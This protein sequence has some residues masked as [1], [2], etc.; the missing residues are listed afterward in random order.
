MYNTKTYC[1][2][3]FITNGFFVLLLASGQ[4]RYNYNMEFTPRPD[5]MEMQT[6]VHTFPGDRHVTKEQYRACINHGYVSSVPTVAGAARAHGIG[7]DTETFERWKRTA[8][9]A[10]LLDD[11]LDTSGDLESAY[12]LYTQGVHYFRGWSEAPVA[13]EE[14]DERLEPG[15]ILLGNAVS[16]LPQEQQGMLCEAAESIAFIALWKAGCWYPDD[17]ADYSRPDMFAE[18][19][20]YEAAD[21]ARLIT[22]TASKSV[23]EHPNFE[24][25][26][27][28]CTQ[29]ITLGALVNN[30]LDLKEDYEHELV[31]VAPTPI[32]RL[33]IA[34]RV[35]APALAMTQDWQNMAATTRSVRANWNYRLHN[36][37]T[38]DIRISKKQRYLY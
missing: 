33:R 11:F 34:C 26:S 17:E 36:T 12:R 7:V 10:S 37:H 27:T 19:I 23:R 14:A 6:P 30:T 22:E 13:P 3:R 28:W 32:N 24:R 29:A 38:S 31:Q 20:K 35:G 8:A 18:L 9:A 21:T 1:I 4:L 16:G 2:R 5:S 25:F 15:I